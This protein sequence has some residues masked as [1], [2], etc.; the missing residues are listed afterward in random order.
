MIK[1]EPI[2]LEEGYVI[3]IEVNFPKTRLLS[4]MAPEIGY[5]MCG[6]LNIEAMDI[7]HGEREIIAVRVTGVRSF[8]DLLNV[9][10][11]E[12]T[13]KAEKIGIKKGMSGREAMNTM[14]KYGRNEK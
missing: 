12:V 6:V 13:N 5:L 1:T 9:E 7:L 10:V 3:G 4:L 11:K 2:K 8:E 14:L